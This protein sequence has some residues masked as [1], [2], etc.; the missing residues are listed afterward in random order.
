[1]TTSFHLNCVPVPASSIKSDRLE[2]MPFPLPVDPD[3]RRQVVQFWL[4]DVEDRLELLDLD[5]AEKSWKLANDIYLSL[6]AGEGDESLE[7]SL[8]QARVKLDHNHNQA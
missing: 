3:F 6:P 5:S 1:M 2:Q 7:S 8:V 4:E